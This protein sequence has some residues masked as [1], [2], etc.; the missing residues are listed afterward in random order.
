MLSLSADCLIVNAK[1]CKNVI[2]V[3]IIYVWCVCLSNSPNKPFDESDNKLLILKG[4]L[5]SGHGLGV[6][7]K[8]RGTESIRQF[9]EYLPWI[10]RD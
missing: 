9:R 5:F 6:C 1:N 4:S 2:T 7:G 3:K 10:V 8:G